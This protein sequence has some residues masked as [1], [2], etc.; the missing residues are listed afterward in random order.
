MPIILNLGISISNNRKLNNLPS[1]IFAKAQSLESFRLHGNFG[2][3]THIELMRNL[4]DPLESLKHLRL[5]G[6]EHSST[7]LSI[8]P[9]FLR[10]S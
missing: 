6:T 3:N 2:G 8:P 7:L 5:V 9:H 1:N 4:L 10:N